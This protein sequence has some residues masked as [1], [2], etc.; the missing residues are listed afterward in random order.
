MSYPEEDN[1]DPET[2]HVTPA[3]IRRFVEGLKR[4]VDW[5]L[6]HRRA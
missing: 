4:T 6:A 2:S 1:F 5:Y 3:L